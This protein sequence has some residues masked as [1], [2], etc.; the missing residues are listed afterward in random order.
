MY[1]NWFN[2]IEG[3]YGKKISRDRL[4]EDQVCWRLVCQYINE[5]MEI[6]KIN[7]L[8]D[9]CNERFFKLSMLFRGNCCLYD[10]SIGTIN[11]MCGLSGNFNLYM[12]PAQLSLYSPGTDPT[13]CEINGKIVECY[14]PGTN[15]EKAKAYLIKD[16]EM[17]YP[18]ILIILDYARQIADTMRAISTAADAL[19][20]PWIFT[21][22]E[23]MKKSLMNIVNSYETNAKC[24]I[25]SKGLEDVNR[26]QLFNT[27][28]NP[29]VLKGLWE[30]L[31]NLENARRQ[32]FGYQGQANTDKRERLLVD[33][34]NSNNQITEVNGNMRLNCINRDL[35][36]YNKTHGTAIKAELNYKQEDLQNVQLDPWDRR[37]A[38]A[39]TASE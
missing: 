9:T 24:I 36:Y 39:Q 21:C 15:N 4:M 29:E 14:M 17:M 23:E 5:Y 22:P 31:D 1:I 30:H 34:V 35:D 27:G 8:P 20:V 32:L 38:Q 7:G 3:D 33:E 19:K 16:N 12:E 13:S 2:L 11:T 10:S 25:A 37:P 28:N 26:S 6:M 18:Y